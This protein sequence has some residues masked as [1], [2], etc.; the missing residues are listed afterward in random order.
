[1]RDGYDTLFNYVNCNVFF[2]VVHLIRVI[3]RAVV[4]HFG[5]IKV[6]RWRRNESRRDDRRRDSLKFTRRIYIEINKE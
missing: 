6:T 3:S 4:E 2:L 1:M 5:A